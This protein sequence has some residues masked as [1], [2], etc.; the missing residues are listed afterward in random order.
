VVQHGRVDLVV[1]G[2]GTAGLVAAIGA[3]AQGAR[4][5]LVERDRTGGDCLWTGCVPSKALLEVARRAH[6]ARTSG[7]LGV[8]AREV[9]VGFAAAMAHVQASIAAIEPHDAPDRLR[10]EGVEVVAGEGRF[11]APDALE[12]HGRRLRFRRALV[13]TGAA[14][15]LPAIPGLTAAAPLTSETV[16]ALTELPARLLVLGAGAIGVELGQAFARLGAEVTLVDEAALPLPRAGRRAGEVLAAALAADGVDLRLGQRV[17]HL[18]R[19]GDGGI[20]SLVAVDGGGTARTDD[21]AFDR[22]LVAAGRVP[23]TDGLGLDRAQVRRRADGAI[24]V[25]RSLRTS[26]PRIY[27]A[28]DVTGLLPFTHVAAAHGAAVVQHAL[29]RLPARV[30]HT[31][32]PW[33]IFT[34]PEVGRVGLDE[35]EARARYGD[36]ARVRTVDHRDLDRAIAGA[37]TSGF[38][39]L[40]G[41][42]RGRL[43]GAT[44]VGPRAGE[45]IAELAVWL[46]QGARLRDLVRTTHPYPTWSEGATEASLAELR[47]GLARLRPLTRAVLALQRLSR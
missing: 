10:A 43:V 46:G 4:V 17:A 20:A 13:A 3:A 42:P 19:A 14:P 38:T 30:D 5:V 29:F 15:A 32:L 6:V 26:N 45:T 22:L 40:V 11:V 36:E 41:D 47:G 23:R 39:Q 27:A 18:D 9:R 1:L 37:A 7:S 25:D 33:T 28:G 12:V 31:R 35:H 34:D 2:G 16:W 8:E 21:V 44:V 24:A